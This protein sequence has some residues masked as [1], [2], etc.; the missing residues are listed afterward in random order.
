MLEHLQYPVTV[1]EKYN[2][3]LGILSTYNGELLFCSK[4]EDHLS[5]Y[6]DGNEDERDGIPSNYMALLF[7]KQFE[8]LVPEETQVKIK[9]WLLKKNCSMLFEVINPTLDPHIVPYEENRLVLLDIVYNDIEK[10]MKL[11]G[12]ES[13][14]ALNDGLF[15]LDLKQII[16]TIDDK[17]KMRDFVEAM[18]TIKNIGK[19]GYVCKDSKGYM[20]KFKTADYMF[21][22]DMRT[23]CGAINGAEYGCIPTYWKVKDYMADKYYEEIVEYYEKYFHKCVEVL[24]E[25]FGVNRRDDKIELPPGFMNRPDGSKMNILDIRKLCEDNIKM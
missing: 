17:D 18:F 4:S 1:F 21:W 23:M 11:M 22:K 15:H 9:D 25:K 8:E 10:P 16:Y 7:K 6:S 14:K 2:G 24:L 13:L 3:F 12:Y 20:I 5:T 19:E